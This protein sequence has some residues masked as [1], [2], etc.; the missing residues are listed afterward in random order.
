MLNERREQKVRQ[1]QLV[2]RNL[3]IRKIEKLSNL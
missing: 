3:T 1:G 2:A